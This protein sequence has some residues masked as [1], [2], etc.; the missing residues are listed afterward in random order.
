MMDAISLLRIFLA[1]PRRFIHRGQSVRTAELIDWRPQ[2]R[3]SRHEL[4]QLPYSF[5]FSCPECDGAGQWKVSGQLVYWQWLVCGVGSLIINNSQVWSSGFSSIVIDQSDQS[6]RS[7]S[8]VLSQS[9]LCA[10]KHC[11]SCVNGSMTVL[12]STLSSERATLKV[13]NAFMHFPVSHWVSFGFEGSYAF[14]SF[15]LMR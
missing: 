11:C 14:L 13:W 12:S 3:F 15:L 6:C 1:V 4:D 2:V 5:Q 10:D 7:Y 8:L 9:W